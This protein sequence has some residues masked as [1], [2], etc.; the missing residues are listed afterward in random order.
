MCCRLRFL[1]LFALCFLQAIIAFAQSGKYTS[2]TVKDGLPSNYI[3]LILE[4]D[5]GF[6]WVSTDAGLARF[7]GKNFQIYTTK[8]GL[9]DNEVLSVMK[10][11]DGR[12]WAECF[13]RMPVYFDEVQNRFVAPQ[14][15][16]STLTDINNTVGLAT[17]ILKNGGISYSN[18]DNWIVFKDAKQKEYPSV[19]QKFPSPPIILEEYEDGS[20]LVASSSILWKST[21]DERVLRNLYYI[22]DNQITDSLTLMEE[23]RTQAGLTVNDGKLYK[24]GRYKNECVVYSDFQVNPIRYK[25]VELKIPEFYH[26]YFFTPKY[27]CFY[28]ES[29]KMYLYGHETLQFVK[30]VSGDYLANAFYDDSKGNEWISTIDKG[31][32]VF[33]SRLP[34]KI[35][36][37]ENF[38]HTNFMS[39]AERSDGTLFAGNYYGEVLEIKDEKTV[40]HKIIDHS[41]ARIRKILFSGNDVYTFSEEGIYRNYTQRIT[42]PFR[43]DMSF[44]KTAINAND[45]TILVGTHRNMFGIDTR[46]GKTFP[47]KSADKRITSIAK[48]NTDWVYFGSTDGLYKYNIKNDETVSLTHKNPLLKNRVLSLCYTQ[49]GLLWVGMSGRLLVL[50]NDEILQV[51]ENE[52]VAYNSIRHITTGKPGDV[53]VATSGGINVLNYKLNGAKISHTERTISTNDGLTSNDV[54]ELFYQNGKIYAATANGISIIPED[55]TTPKTDIPTYLVHIRINGKEAEIQD[56]YQLDYGQQ[57]IQMQFAGVDLNGYFKHLQYAL[58]NSD[59]VN[60]NENTLNIRL[61]TGV[62]KIKVR[63]VDVNGNISSKELNITFDVEVPFWQKIGFWLICGVF[64]QVFLFWIIRNYLKKK[65]EAALAQKIAE[66]QTAALE[67]Q[68]FTSLMSPHFI[69]N[70][71]NGIQYY[72][73]MQ[74]RKNANRYLS[75]FASLI[76]RNLNAAQQSF[77]SLEEEIENSKLYLELEK[78]RFSERFRYTIQEDEDLDISEWMIPTMILQPLLENAVLHGIMP[79]GER[80]IVQIRFA[81]QEQDLLI[82]VIDNGIGIANSQALKTGNP[83]KSKGMKLI[84]KRIKALS[85]FGT[86][87]ISVTIDPAFDSITN[88][89]TKITLIIPFSL[90]GNWYISQKH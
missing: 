72:I 70:A 36:L 88:P 28:G 10:E 74:D 83:H 49:D 81:Q 79:S 15:K 14:I 80:G 89:G 51:F 23:P 3:Y 76:R 29:G 61:G 64:V 63:S 38:T 9:P 68:A 62:H 20:L 45:T 7:D 69:F 73:N 22:R 86:K 42:Y 17:R 13:A 46:T 58:D 21:A 34:E 4:D 53:W 90:Y 5:K 59:W 54:Q 16:D 52:N 65:R 44:G 1:F 33:R 26:N 11:K 35:P 56:K 40:V 31:L 8:N 82:T 87:P 60:L 50:K 12:I 27:L 55:Y 77:I 71:L 43:K 18:R 47:T 84:F 25:A 2:F 85:Y 19:L 41:P 37:P 75:D 78:M 24:I 66:V 32:L 6:L 57:D 67:Q 48:A 39:I 30:V